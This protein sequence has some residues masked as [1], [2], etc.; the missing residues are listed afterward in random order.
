MN[1]LSPMIAV[2]ATAAA[3][4]LLVALYYLK[5]KRRETLISSTL[6]WKRAVQDLQVNAPFQRL[7]RNLL[8]LLQLLALAAALA[9]L[10]RPVLSL[11]T[12]PPQRYVLLIDR[13]ASMNATDVPPTR[14]EA[15]K[16]QAKELI[17]SLRGR[18]S[19]TM[20]DASDQAMV[21]AFDEHAQVMCNFTSDKRQ[22]EAAVDSIAPTD[23]PTSLAEAITVAQ[24]Y[25]QPPGE[26]TNNRSAE[27]RAQLELFSD[28]QI[29]DAEQISLAAGE[30]RFHR[31]GESRRNVA[32]TAMQARRSYEK[33]DEVEVF[34]TLAN[35]G[36]QA[37][38]C[39]VQL[40]LDG[41]VRSVRPVT[42]PPGPP[43][44]PAG[45]KAAPP[46]TVSVS[47]SLSHSQAGVVEV[48]ARAPAAD[49][50]LT[51]DDAAWA[52][53]PPPRSLR[54]LLVTAGNVVLT[55]A[56]KA[57][58]LLRLETCTP[59]EFDAMDH[60][61]L[62]ANPRYDVFILDE[63]SPAKLPR[64]RFLVFGRPPPAS[65]VTSSGELRNQLV[66][67][68]RGRHPVLQFV[69]MSNLFAAK[70]Y[71]V[72]APSDAAVLAE[73]STSPALLLVR[74]QGSVFLL[75]PFDCAETNWPFEPGFVVFCYNATA[76]LGLEVGLEGSERSALRVGGAISLEG[77]PPGA[78]VKVAGPG[79]P[80]T[81]LAASPTGAV[82]FPGT[83]RVGVYTVSAPPRP[84][85]R[86][87]VNLLDEAEGRIEPSA[88]LRLLGQSVAA[89]PSVAKGAVEL[90]PWLVLLALA[91]VCLE[92]FVYKRKV[93]V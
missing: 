89:Q 14:L 93:R 17:A 79:T 76:Y 64:G 53:L 5:L 24:A 33:P 62:S 58:P 47:F 45:A 65:G 86:F 77:L 39:D 63:H 31:V 4:P 59:A 18:T 15:A 92:W 84:T 88:A 60:S 49:N 68:W 13:S 71:K 38:G 19:F 22:L 80:E 1:W 32:V 34:A 12:A 43:T 75:A 69:N 91:L 90:A 73:F 72:A 6:L 8:L 81:E 23:A 85:A 82:R 16:R 20:G 67:D 57:C 83:S 30:M 51:S 29:P 70:C 87:A 40:G 28:G 41:D 21:V 44:P 48:R 3:V 54:A 27:V 9:A 2:Y 25:A 35:Y 52:V 42:V 11:T 66:V 78:A 37:A 55:S 36:A 50:A 61:A 74:R 7:R 46:G 26:A 56:L 10:G